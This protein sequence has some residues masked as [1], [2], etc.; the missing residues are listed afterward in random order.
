MICGD[1]LRRVGEA[2]LAV[3]DLAADRELVVEMAVAQACEARDLGGDP[4]LAHE[5]FVARRDRLGE[6]ELVRLRACI[7]DAANPAI[8]GH[9]GV[10][11]TRLAFEDLPAGRVDAALRRIGVDLDL[12]VLVALPLDPALALLDLRGEPGHVEMMEGL[13]APLGVDAGAHGL[14]RSDQDSDLAPIDGIEQPLLRGGFLV[15]LHEGDL[16]C[17]DAAR[18]EAVSDPAIGREPARLLGGQGAEV[19]EDHLRGAGQGVGDA[20]SAG[21]PVVCGAD[22]DL[23]NLVDQGVELVFGLVLLRS[24]G[25]SG[26]RSRRGGRR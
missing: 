18:D 23:V 25:R 11:E 5:P 12:V 19:G 20:V 17:R 2:L 3:A 15:V 21:E 13:Q 26:G 14:G 6:R 4:R 16:I 10:D 24:S 1:P 9:G 8:A 7:L 22:P